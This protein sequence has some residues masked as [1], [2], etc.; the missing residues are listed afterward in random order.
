MIKPLT[1]EEH[2]E[3]E[4]KG[5]LSPEQIRALEDHGRINVNRYTEDGGTYR[6]KPSSY[7]GAI[8]IGTLSVVVRPKVS[9]DT[10]MFMITYAIDPK[11]WREHLTHL[12]P[13]DGLLEA[14]AL[15]FTIRTWQAVQRG[16]LHGYKETEDALSTVRGRINFGEQIR[17]HYSIPLPI[18]VVFDEYTEDIE[19]NRLLKTAIHRLAHSLIRNDNVR[20]E[21]LRLWPIFGKVGLATYTRGKLPPLSFTR[22]DEHYRWPVELARLII[23][24]S[25]LELYQGQVSG[26]AFFIDMNRV[27]ELFL[28]ISLK[29][30]LGSSDYQWKHGESMVLDKDGRISIEPD[31]SRWRGGT[32]K[33]V[34]DAKYKYLEPKGY[35]HADIYQ[36]LAYCT[37][38]C[39]PSGLLVYAAG[40]DQQPGTYTID[41]INKTIEVATLDLRGGPQE[42]LKEVERIAGL[43][44]EHTQP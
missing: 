20:D 34:G 32:C 25:I 16:L 14:I 35:K 41:H 27:F 17:R 31:I 38:A 11:R 19:K 43:V 6:L 39:L 29:E 8:N 22:L 44:I 28:S 30:K 7:I 1:L 40:E 3:Y 33:F 42:I 5:Q 13:S 4:W 18:E 37:A 21:V 9:I 2:R 12:R 23:E 26:A 24:N 10:V 36:M 15:A